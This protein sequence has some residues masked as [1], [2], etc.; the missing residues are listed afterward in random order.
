VPRGLPVSRKEILRRRGARDEAEP[1]SSA[2]KD[3]ARR[4]RTLPSIGKRMARQDGSE[5][6]SSL[7]RRVSR[8]DILRRRASVEASAQSNDVAASRTSSS[9]QNSRRADLPRPSTLPKILHASR[10]PRVD[11]YVSART[12]ESAGREAPIYGRIRRRK[13][14]L[15]TGA[16]TLRDSASTSAS[17]SLARFARSRM[18]G[19][20]AEMATRAT[21]RHLRD[22]VPDPPDRSAGFTREVNAEDIYA[23]VTRKSASRQTPGEEKLEPIDRTIS[24]QRIIG[25]ANQMD[26]LERRMHQDRDQD[27]IRIRRD[28]ILVSKA[29]IERSRNVRSRRSDQEDSKAA[30][31]ATPT[32]SKRRDSRTETW[33]R[34]AHPS[35]DSVSDR[36]A[37]CRSKSHS[38][39]LT[40]GP[41]ENPK[42]GIGRPMTLPSYVKIGRRTSSTGLP[43]RSVDEPGR[44]SN[45]GTLTK[46]SKERSNYVRKTATRASAHARALSDAVSA[47][48]N[49]PD[50]SSSIFGFCTGRRRVQASSSSLRSFPSWNVKRVK[51]RLSMVARGLTF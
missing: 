46:Q 50:T 26:S 51:S 12:R 23:K 14:S 29:D 17:S 24:R 47:R 41:R 34:D 32:W 45:G 22:P 48:S 13:M 8:Q 20:R 49:S 18:S 40:E 33:S 15:P 30:C 44:A 21:V 31:R 3:Q 43:A 37:K 10:T 5:H 25:K 28:A 4:P 2:D 27:V 9:L 11:E 39:P 35:R 38:G 19:E 42:T 7:L 36:Q 6:G 16:T 1:T